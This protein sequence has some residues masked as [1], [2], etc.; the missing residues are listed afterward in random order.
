[1]D[2]TEDFIKKNFGKIKKA[3]KGDIDALNDL[4]KA[5]AKEYVASLD[6]YDKATPELQATINT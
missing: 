3:M 1:M 4:D 5:A 2:F 6:Y